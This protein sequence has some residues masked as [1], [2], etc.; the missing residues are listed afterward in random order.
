MQGED[1]GPTTREGTHDAYLSVC[2]IYRNEA[3]YLREWVAFHRLMGVER[4][5]LYDNASTDDHRDALAPFLEDGSVVLTD[6]PF[7][8]GQISAFDDCLE[9]RRDASRWI[10]FLDLDE[11]LFSPTGLPVPKVLEDYERH[12]GVGVNWAMFG[13]S[14]RKTKPDGL[15]IES[16]LRRSVDDYRKNR[17]IKSIV[18]PRHVERCSESP[19]YFVYRDGNPV[20]ERHEP[21]EKGMTES[22]SFSRLRINHYWTKSEEECQRKLSKGKADRLEARAPALSNFRNTDRD[23]LNE[24]YDDTILR[25]ASDLHA[26]LDCLRAERA[27]SVAG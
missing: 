23:F 10:A 4:L 3:P 20:N 27:T 22:V 14:G 18:D 12:A 24:R 9:R 25:F 26:T 5:F 6:W 21:F 2:A 15:V 13:S 19:H 7:F 1:G 17:F 8:P 16:Y 11:F